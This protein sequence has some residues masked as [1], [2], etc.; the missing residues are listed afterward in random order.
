MRKKKKVPE[1]VKVEKINELHTASITNNETIKEEKPPQKQGHTF[2]QDF[3][4]PRWNAIL[5]L[6]VQS[7]FAVR[8]D[9]FEKADSA[10]F[11]RAAPHHTT[12]THRSTSG[13]CMTLDGMDGLHHPSR[14]LKALVSNIHG[15]LELPWML[16]SSPFDKGVLL[17]YHYYYY[18]YY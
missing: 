3:C 5:P 18:Y 14:G 8:I 10:S 2:D 9:S 15:A 4:L 13:A 6:F 17:Y 7:I 16:G 12:P 1:I 11:W